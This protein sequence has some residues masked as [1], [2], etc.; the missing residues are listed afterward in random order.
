[1][2]LDHAGDVLIGQHITDLEPIG[3]WTAQGAVEAMGGT[4]EYYDGQGLPA[5][6]SMMTEEDRVVRF[7]LGP[8]GD[9][10]APVDQPGPFDVRIGMSREQAMARFPTPPDS[11]PHPY[12]GAQG[13]FLTWQDP[14]SDLGMRLDL[15]E[16]KVTQIYWGTSDAIEFNEGCA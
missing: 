7:D 9:P 16:G 3:P 8:G 4:C 11:S 5:G 14:G 1:V 12:N 10:A 6:M 13:E 15:F 2:A